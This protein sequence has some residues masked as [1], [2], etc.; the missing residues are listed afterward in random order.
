MKNDL[1]RGYGSACGKFILLG[2]HFVVH[3]SAAIA[4]PIL[5]FKCE[6]SVSCVLRPKYSARFPGPEMNHL[7]SKMQTACATA[8]ER[9]GSGHEIKNFSLK[10]VNSVYSSSNF[11]LSKGFG[12]SA[13]FSLA[14]VRSLIDFTQ[15][16]DLNSHIDYST[17]TILQAVH[18][19]EK[20]FHGNPSGLDAATIY[21]QTPIIFQKEENVRS[22]KNQSADFILLDSGERRESSELISEIARDKEMF[23][24]KWL[25]FVSQVTGLVR[26][27]EKIFLKGS[28]DILTLSKIVNEAHGILASMKLSTDR[29][30]QLISQS[31]KLGAKAGKV[32]GAGA[33]GAVVILAEKGRGQ[34]LSN[35]FVENHLPV[36]GVVLAE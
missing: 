34:E 20:T 17:E 33:G 36:V 16:Q 14:L 27:A 24:K 31:I 12:S 9:L 29:I 22:F 32:S 21:Y 30:S 7:E 10:N 1:T 8:V 13:S 18:D 6:V 35:C 5:D 3:G 2:E 25:E 11:P 23:P 26:D 15:K 28:L 4:L 19:V